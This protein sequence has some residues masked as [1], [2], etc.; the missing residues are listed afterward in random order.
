MASVLHLHQGQAHSSSSCESPSYII[1]PYSM[2]ALQP[3]KDWHLMLVVLVMVLMDSLIAVTVLPL[4]NARASV[5]IIPN[6]QNP[7]FTRN[8]MLKVLVI[9]QPFF[10]FGL[11]KLST[12]LPN[13]HRVK[14]LGKFRW[15]L[16][17]HHPPNPTGWE[18]SLVIRSSSRPLVCS[19]PS[20]SGR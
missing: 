15:C 17:V 1:T 10:S 8:V 2:N 6:K 16:D 3:L 19:W 13:I 9:Y 11:P 7:G 20:R 12:L 4:D 5:I 14:V 18:F